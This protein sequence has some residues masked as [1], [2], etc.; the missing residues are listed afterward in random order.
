MS[1]YL[2]SRRPASLAHWL[3]EEL[4]VPL[5]QDA[6]AAL[7]ACAWSS[8]LDLKIV[9]NQVRYRVH[10]TSDSIAAKFSFAAS[11]RA[12]YRVRYRVNWS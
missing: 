5:A 8:V 2:S 9:S 4:S 6:L 3:E 7:C 11:F 1:S 10:A 12:L